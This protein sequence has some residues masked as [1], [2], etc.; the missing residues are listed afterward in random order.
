LWQQILPLPIRYKT[1]IHS[2]SYSPAM[3]ETYLSL[4]SNL[5]NRKTFINR[6][7][8][9]IPH[10]IGIILDKSSIY[11]TE[12]WGFHHPA[13]FYN[14]V[15]LVETLLTPTELLLQCLSIERQLGRQRQNNKYEAR[16]ID[17]DILFYDDQILLQEGLQIPHPY[18]HLRKFVLEPLN[19][20]AAGL[21]H[22]V[23]KKT[24][25][26]ILESCQDHGKVVRL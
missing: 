6:A 13:N 20:I 26:K 1:T 11:E 14:Q 24:I 23:L 22:P 3:P 5:G 21:L 7:L 15:L 17:I 2:G 10:E 25:G 8:K 19:E 9:I 12:P 4:G 18:L 16:T